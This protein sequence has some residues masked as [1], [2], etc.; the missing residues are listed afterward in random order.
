MS[1]AV[2][3]GG[4]APVIDVEEFVEARQLVAHYRALFQFESRRL[5]GPQAQFPFDAGFRRGDERRFAPHGEQRGVVGR[6]D[7]AVAVAAHGDRCAVQTGLLAGQSR[8]E[9]GASGNGMSYCSVAAS[10]MRLRR[11]YPR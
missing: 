4:D 10:G 5:D 2:G 9:V 3:E 8:A 6:A 7:D 1:V 11:S